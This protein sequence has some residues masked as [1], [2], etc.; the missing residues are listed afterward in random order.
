MNIQISF[1]FFNIIYGRFSL[2]YVSNNKTI[3]S[4]LIR[5]FF[6]I[7]ILIFDKKI[8]GKLKESASV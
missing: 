6:F 8:V 7:I 5:E 1:A 2:R 4:T 3:F